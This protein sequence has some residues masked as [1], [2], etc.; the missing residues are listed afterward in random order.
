MDPSD[1]ILLLKRY[2][3]DDLLS[4]DWPFRSAVVKCM[5]LQSPTCFNP[6]QSEHICILFSGNC[7]PSLPE[8][9]PDISTSLCRS[10]WIPSWRRSGESFEGREASKA[11]GL[12]C[13]CEIA[14]GKISTWSYTSCCWIFTEYMP[15]WKEARW[16]SGAGLDWQPCPTAGDWVGSSICAWQGNPNNEISCHCAALRLTVISW[17]TPTLQ[18]KCQNMSKWMMKTSNYY[19]IL[20]TCW[21][22]WWLGCHL[23]C[24][25]GGSQ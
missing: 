12:H 19:L 21:I 17:L 6:F 8:P 11:K 22:A 10:D 7:S 23:L 14:F 2:S 16:S 25:H 18:L 4:Q 9:S 3:S 1:A 15:D 5:C 13:S 24:E 20:L